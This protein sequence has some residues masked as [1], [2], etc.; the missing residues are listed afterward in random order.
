MGFAAG[1]TP[2]A[3]GYENIEMSRLQERG[4][5]GS[6][7]E[8]GS[9]PVVSESATTQK[10]PGCPRDREVPVF[11]GKSPGDVE[12]ERL[13][14]H[15]RG[16]G[17]DGEQG[18]PSVSCWI[19]IAVAARGRILGEVGIESLRRAWEK[20][21]MLHAPRRPRSFRPNRSKEKSP[22]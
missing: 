15:G 3:P 8:I 4:S 19:R 22:S 10:S 20:G 6:T 9:G 1:S 13:G 18:S 5:S 17:G 11:V 21:D 7:I 12:V 2:K 16:D 14:A